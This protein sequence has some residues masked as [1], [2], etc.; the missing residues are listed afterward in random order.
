VEL[1]LIPG[2]FTAL[3]STPDLFQKE[4]HMKVFEVTIQYDRETVANLM[5]FIK[6]AYNKRNAYKV[7]AMW[8]DCLRWI[9]D[10]AIQ[11]YSADNFYE[12]IR[13]W[14]ENHEEIQNGAILKY[15]EVKL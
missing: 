5:I 9:K 2:A 14:I 1:G 11:T 10:S 8:M 12:L 15:Q 6:K 7:K 13:L 4:E 3:P